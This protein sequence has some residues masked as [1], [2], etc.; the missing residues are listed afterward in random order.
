MF[1]TAFG[2]DGTSNAPSKSA[3]LSS[4][5]KSTTGIRNALAIPAI[6]QSVTVLRWVSMFAIMQRVIFIPIA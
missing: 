5:K 2:G 6:W 1:L 3:G 4:L